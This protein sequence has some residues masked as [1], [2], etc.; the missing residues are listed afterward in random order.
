MSQKLEPLGSVGGTGPVPGSLL[1][2]EKDSSPG[3]WSVVSALQDAA[4]FPTTLGPGHPASFYPREGRMCLSQ[5]VQLICQPW[6]GDRPHREKVEIS[7]V[8]QAWTVFE[9]VTKHTNYPAQLPEKI[10]WQATPFFTVLNKFT[11]LT[12]LKWFWIR[13]RKES[14]YTPVWLCLLALFC[15]GNKP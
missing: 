2:L 14:S 15:S 3:V 8:L 10:R 4:P 7:Q 6:D 13:T 9:T 1:S 11:P 5:S 12:I